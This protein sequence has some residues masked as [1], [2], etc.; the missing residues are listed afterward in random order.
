MNE[1]LLAILMSLA[2]IYVTCVVV[3]VIIRI[4][5]PGLIKKFIQ[6]IHKHE[7]VEVCTYRNPIN[8][9]TERYLRCRKCGKR[10]M[11]VIYDK[12]EMRHEKKVRIRSEKS[13]DDKC[14]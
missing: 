13:G 7:W 10:E 11:I 1:T 6:F 3:F 9:T 14:T 5:I 2:F 12:L 4:I 8:L